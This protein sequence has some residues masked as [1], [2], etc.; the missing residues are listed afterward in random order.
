MGECG[1][2]EWSDSGVGS[3][4]GCKRVIDPVL[5]DLYVEQGSSHPPWGFLGEKHTNSNFQKCGEVKK[6]HLPHTPPGPA[7]V[8]PVTQRPTPTG[9]PAAPADPSP[10]IAQDLG[11]SDPDR[12]GRRR[13][14]LPLASSALHHH[15]HCYLLRPPLP[16]PP[17]PPLPAVRSG[18]PP[19]FRS[20]SA[21]S[22]ARCAP[23]SSAC[24]EAGG[25]P[26]GPSA[27]RNAEGQRPEPTDIQV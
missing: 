23:H 12:Q 13:H 19:W 22:G 15:H 4:V 7:R 10:D 9:A 16:L 24:P 26:A 11:V 5:L 8:H 6:S 1:D 3:G 18:V 2:N 20:C 25:R 17:R 14:Q 21:E 27:G